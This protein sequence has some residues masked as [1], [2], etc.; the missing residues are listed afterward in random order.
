MTEDPAGTAGIHGAAASALGYQ[1]QVNWGLIE[2]LRRG[3]TRPDQS[4]TLELHDDVAWDQ[5][6]HPIERI[7]V[8]HHLDREAALTDASVDV[9][10]T[11]KVWMDTASPADPNG[12]LLVLVTT[13][14]AGPGSAAA[15]LRPDEGRDESAA[16]AALVATAE[17][18]TNQTTA[19]AREQF[20]TLSAADREVFISRAQVLDGQPGVA[21]LDAQL[22]QHL[23]LSLPSDETHANTYLDLVWRWWSSVSLDLL[24]GVRAS[25]D[26]QEVRQQ[27]AGIRDMFQADNLPT[28]VELDDVDES[29]TVDL[30]VDRPF[31]HQ[32]RWVRVKVDNLRTA[33][34]DYHRAVTQTTNWLDRDLIGIAEL[35]RFERNLTDEWRRAYGDMMEDL[36]D[37]ASDDVKAEMGRALLRKLRDSTAVTVRSRYTDAFFARG[38]RHELADGGSIGWHPEFQT[39]LENLLAGSDEVASG[40]SAA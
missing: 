7:Q 14:T 25:V 28:L 26:V 13:A 36:P 6:G 2:L 18:S 23:W 9:W 27:L 12:A 17:A 39:L 22:K 10:R 1:Y 37:D 19:P 32:M 30:H 21:D 8:K 16:L 35:E 38:K 33:I 5:A 4:L 34:V 11:L 15:W 31:V 29:A 24:L 20:L 3:A 40:G